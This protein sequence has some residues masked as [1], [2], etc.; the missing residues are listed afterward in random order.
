[1]FKNEEGF[2]LLELSIAAA[3]AVAVGAA[4]VAVLATVQGEATAAAGDYGTNAQNS[5]DAVDAVVIPAV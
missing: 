4:A 2:S 5:V 1:M 3:I